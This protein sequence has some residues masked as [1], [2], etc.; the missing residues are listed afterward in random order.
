VNKEGIGGKK[1]FSNMRG[2]GR[3][4]E[5]RREQRREERVLW[6]GCA[7]HLPDGE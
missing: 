5:Q 3:K 2:G 1:L 6:H 7:V 4:R